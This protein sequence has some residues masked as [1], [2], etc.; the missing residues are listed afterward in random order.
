MRCRAIWATGLLIGIFAPSP[1]GADPASIIAH[2][3]G[4]PA[5]RLDL[6]LARL[7]ETIDARGATAGYGGFADIEDKDI[8]IRAYSATVKPDEVNCRRI[9]DRI[10][11]AAGVDPKTGHPEDPASAYA[12]LFRYAGEDESKIDPSYSDTVDSMLA[13][14]VVLGETGNG[15][16]M[17]CQSRLLSNKITYQKQ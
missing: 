3:R 4:T 13:I 16:G 14:M 2:L 5:S 9:L 6:S 8:V 17:V 7:G 15:K 1:A 12:A 10:K 11:A